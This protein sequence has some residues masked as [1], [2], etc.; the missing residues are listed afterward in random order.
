[1]IDAAKLLPCPFCGS[2]ETSHG[3]VQAG[4]VMGNCECHACNACIWAD[5]E[6]D[7]IAA[8]NTRPLATEHIALTA[9]VERLTKLAEGLAGALTDSR[10]ALLSARVTILNLQGSTNPQREA[11]IKDGLAALTAWEGRDHA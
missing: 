11:A 5:A 4:V 3:Y 6:A 2:D 10:Y 1:M 7:A 9:E 8:W